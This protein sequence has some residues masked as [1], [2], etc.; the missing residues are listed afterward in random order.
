MLRFVNEVDAIDADPKLATDEDHQ[1]PFHSPTILES[2]LP[3]VEIPARLRPKQIPLNGRRIMAK[4]QS[5]KEQVKDLKAQEGATPLYAETEAMEPNDVAEF[6]KFME[7]YPSIGEHLE[8][9]AAV[10]GTDNMAPFNNLEF[11]RDDWH[12]K[13]IE[14]KVSQGVIRAFK[15]EYDNGLAMQKTSVS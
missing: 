1:E 4:A 6:S 5:E 14:F 2:R 9:T 11:V 13:F 15:V 3:V 7:F 10:G 8:A 12:I